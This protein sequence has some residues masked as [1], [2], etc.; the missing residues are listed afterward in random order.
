MLSPHPSPS[1]YGPTMSVDEAK[2]L[3]GIGRSQAYA[4][5]RAGTIPAV[6][7]G[8]RWLVITSKLFDMI[9]LNESEPAKAEPETL[10]TVASG[11]TIVDLGDGAAVFIAAGRPIPAVLV[12]LPRRPAGSA[13]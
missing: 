11:D 12:D 5:V 13:A 9:G 6:R 10:V 4:A 3:L 8:D 2:V 1:G 7:V